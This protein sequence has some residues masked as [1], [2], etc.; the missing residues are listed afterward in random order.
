MTY[1]AVKRAGLAH[2][3]DTRYAGR[4]VG[5]AGVSC[6]VLG[7]I[8]ARTVSL[9]FGG[10]S[11]G[12][13]TNTEGDN[14]NNESVVDRSPSICV[15]E[16]GIGGNADGVELLLGLDALEEWNAA[17]CLRDRTLTIRSS[18]MANSRTTNGSTI[19]EEEDDL[20]IPFM[21][22]SGA[23]GAQGALP[24]PK[25]A[26]GIQTDSRRTVPIATTKRTIPTTPSSSSSSSPTS[27]PWV[28]SN[29]NRRMP[30]MADLESDLD[31]LD[32]TKNG[33]AQAYAGMDRRILHSEEGG[34]VVGD[35]DDTALDEDD[36][37]EQDDDEYFESD[38]DYDGC[39]LSG[40]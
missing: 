22:A 9:V 14:D 17:I 26:R 4:A 18:T 15:L 5:V 25:N 2:L 12:G 36:T 33:V 6:T 11:G 16:E 39:N 19:Y 10:C 32:S 34:R 7:R 30:P 29:N 21:N 35:E 23:A 13:G 31:L 28:A 20:C 24:I 38:L 27:I 3:I 37:W 8:P 1:Q 40:I